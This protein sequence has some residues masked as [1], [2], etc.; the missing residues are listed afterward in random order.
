[1]NL[2]NYYYYFQSALTPRLCDDI[3]NYGLQHKPEMALTGGMQESLE[4]KTKSGK[5]KKKAIKEHHVSLQNM[6]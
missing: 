5:L 6:V 3:I 1:M 2:T 4:N